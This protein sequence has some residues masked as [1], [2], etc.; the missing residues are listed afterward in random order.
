M[1]C[2]ALPVKLMY[3]LRRE[4]TRCSLRETIRISPGRLAWAPTTGQ[5]RALRFG[6]ASCGGTATPPVWRSSLTRCPDLGMCEFVTEAS[7]P[8]R[9]AGIEGKYLPALAVRTADVASDPNPRVVHEVGLV[10]RY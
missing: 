2:R 4:A 6:P 5:I 7:Q 1:A 3:G 8:I 9:R 10:G